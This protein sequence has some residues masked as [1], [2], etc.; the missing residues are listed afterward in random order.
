MGV[1][2][3]GWEGGSTSA[4][5]SLPAHRPVLPFRPF[6][7][8]LSST[9]E[10]QI[11]QYHG[12]VRRTAAHVLQLIFENP[13]PLDRKHYMCKLNDFLKPQHPYTR[14]TTNKNMVRKLSSLPCFE[15]FG[16]IFRPDFCSCFCLVCGGGGHSRT[17][18][19]ETISDVKYYT[20]FSTNI[21]MID[22]M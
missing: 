17:K 13:N 16:V 6:L 14:Q 12:F 21:K 4:V 5:H 11:L 20:T 2:F 15:A 1:N 8:G 10:V 18:K 19:S 3:G 7:D 9:W 22:V